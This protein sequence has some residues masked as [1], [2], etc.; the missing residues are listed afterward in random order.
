MAALWGSGSS[1]VLGAASITFPKALRFFGHVLHNLLRHFNSLETNHVYF[2]KA[3][4]VLPVSVKADSKQDWF[5]LAPL[6]LLCAQLSNCVV[7][8]DILLLQT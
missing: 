8:D 4:D 1:L 2:Q 3:V 7:M 6:G 5:L